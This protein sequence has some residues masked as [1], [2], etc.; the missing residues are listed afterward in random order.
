MNISVYVTSYNQKHYVTEA[1]ES[2]L[3]QSLIPHQIIIIDD[4]S[5]DG[6]QDVIAGYASRHPRLIT[7]IYH[8]RN[9]GVAQTRID[10]LQSVTGD[11]VTYVDGD[12][13][14]LP[15]KLEKEAHALR[16]DPSAAIA[17]SNNYYMN[18]GGVHTGVWADGVEPPSGDVFCQTFGRAFPRHSLFRME[19]VN[20]RAWA[21]LGFHD[22]KLTLYEDFDMRI[23]LTKRYSVVY[24]DEPL[25]EIRLH[26]TGLSRAPAVNHLEAVK[27]IYCKN[28]HLLADLDSSQRRAVKL[29]LGQW[30]SGFAR[31]AAQMALKKSAANPANLARAARYRLLNVRYRHGYIGSQ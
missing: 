10:A 12:D 21:K 23:R 11:F 16:Q 6:S 31:R 8:A 25:S 9:C 27:Y 30:M 29:G 20:Y 17:F 2:V 26:K 22:P 7:P 28:K 15:T 19:L 24:C 14:F 13:R 5:S 18:E 3:A 1:I 4:C